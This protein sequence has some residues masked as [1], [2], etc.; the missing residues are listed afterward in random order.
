MPRLQAMT[1]PAADSW[2]C[3]WCG[4]PFL[5]GEVASVTEAGEVFCG[6]SCAKQAEA[7]DEDREF[8]RLQAMEARRHRAMDAEMRAAS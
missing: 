3:G 2:E 6:C 1:M 4:W 8:Q 5:P 7:A